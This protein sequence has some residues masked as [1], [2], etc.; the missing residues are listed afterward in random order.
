MLTT[1]AAL[2]ASVTR[3]TRDSSVSLR[4]IR[5]LQIHVA[6]MDIAAGAKE[7]GAPVLC[8]LAT[9]SATAKMV[10]LVRVTKY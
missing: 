8:R 2:R 1:Q 7:T 4:S 10:T 9:L 3:A 5:A 6:T